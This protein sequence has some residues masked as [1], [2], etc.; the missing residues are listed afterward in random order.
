MG[1][2]NICFRREIR[3]NIFELSSI[4]PLT[5]S[6]AKVKISESLVFHGSVSVR[7]PLYLGSS[8]WKT[9]SILLLSLNLTVLHSKKASYLRWRNKGNSVAA[10]YFLSSCYICSKCIRLVGHLTG[11]SEILGSIPGLATYFRFSFH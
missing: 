11:K 8:I 5:L 3:K 10:K 1:G 7:G 6:S 9:E 2:H 4:L